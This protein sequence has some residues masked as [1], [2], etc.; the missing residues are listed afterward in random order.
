MNAD[1]YILLGTGIGTCLSAVATFLTVQQMA[2]QRKASYK[3][4]LTLPQTRFHAVANPPNLPILWK[5]GYAAKPDESSSAKAG[6]GVPLLNLGLSVAKQVQVSWSFDIQAVVERLNEMAQRSSTQASASYNPTNDRVSFDSDTLGGL[7]SSWRNQERWIDYVLP[8][9][10]QEVPITLELP[11]AYVQL[12]S[13]WVLL[14]KREKGRADFQKI[15]TM[16]LSFDFL[17]IGEG[18][19]VARFLVHCEVDMIQ[20][21]LYEAW[22]KFKKIE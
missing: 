22:L 17:D 8:A 19:H 21:E 4:E 5:K 3:P 11:I 7:S 13:A 16:N 9:A 12:V 14:G 1:Q 10:Y 2:R 18:K 15:P 20:G 6:F